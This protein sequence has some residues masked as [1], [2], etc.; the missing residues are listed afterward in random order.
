MLLQ[1]IELLFSDENSAKFG[2]ICDWKL[3][4]IDFTVTNF[5]SIKEPQTFSY[6]VSKAGS[7]LP[8]NVAYPSD[9]K[10]GVLKTSAVYG[11][12]ASGKSNLIQA[13]KALRF[14]AINDIN[15]GDSIPCYEPFL[16]SSETKNAPVKFEIEF[17]INSSDRFVYS[18][19]FT[20]NEVVEE[21]LYYFK[22]S[23]KSLI[24]DRKAHNTWRDI[25]FG[26]NYK[27]GR[28]QIAF[29]SNNSYLSKA[30]N[31]ADS[32]EIV[33]NVFKYLRRGLIFVAAG[34]VR[35]SKKDIKQGS[36]IEQ[37]AGMIKHVDTG[38][39]NIDVVE[40][41][42]ILSNKFINAFPDDIKNQIIEDQ[43][44]RFM[45]SHMT[46]DGG[47]EQFHEDEESAGTI[48]M[49]NLFPLVMKVFYLGGVLVFDEIERHLHPHIAEMVIKLF[50]D[51][52]VNRRNAQLLFTSHN[53]QLM[54]SDQLR[55]DQIW[56]I[57]K[58]NGASKFASLASFDKDMVRPNSPFGEWYSQGRFG[59][60][61]KINYLAIAE[62]IRKGFQ[63]DA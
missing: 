44:T 50:C 54:S 59:A 61:P 60:I 41:D 33:Q 37:I 47:L 8:E 38:I 24:F 26:S 62:E 9:K 3:M 7:I 12:N 40:S 22:S 46:E 23:S 58:I 39:E 1:S 49:L 27:G 52:Q 35:S 53:A 5:R 4:I 20:R 57:Q 48:A 28:K 6:F 30:G 36:L 29:F 21:S 10:I 42:E 51:P 17:Y 19:A 56:F 13:L 11:A 34:S 25:T 63:K 32:P 43:K 2:F 16:L 15:D 55:R 14:I 31:T 45:F 18:I